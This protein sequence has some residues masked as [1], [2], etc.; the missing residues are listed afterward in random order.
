[1]VLLFAAG[2][3]K[4]WRAWIIF[5]VFSSFPS[6]LFQSSEG[7][8]VFRDKLPLSKLILKTVLLF[9]EERVFLAT[10]MLSRRTKFDR[11]EMLKSQLNRV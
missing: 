6:F 8:V 4:S 2:R 1:M 9:Y 7:R 3:D 5:P 11:R 10:E